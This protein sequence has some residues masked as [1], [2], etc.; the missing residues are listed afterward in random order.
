MFYSNF[1]DLVCIRGNNIHRES[2]KMKKKLQKF[3][4]RFTVACLQSDV[5]SVSVTG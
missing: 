1:F 2:K 5:G 3:Y 4:I